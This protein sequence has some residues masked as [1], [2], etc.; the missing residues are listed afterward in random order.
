MHRT[1]IMMVLVSVLCSTD[2]IGQS[3]P[4]STMQDSFNAPLYGQRGGSKPDRLTFAVTAEIA[5]P[6]PLP[7]G[8]PDLDGEFLEI[9]VA[10]GIARTSWS[11]GSTLSVRPAD[12][13]VSGVEPLIFVRWSYDPARLHRSQALPSGL[14]YTQKRQRSSSSRWHKTWKLRVS[15]NN[16]A[17][18][19]LTDRRVFFGSQNNRVYGLRKRNGH[20]V[21]STDLDQRISRRLVHYQGQLEAPP[22]STNDAQDLE[23]ILVLPDPGSRLIALDAATGMLV[24]EYNL[25]RD[26][27]KFVGVPVVTPDAQVV[28]AKES[29]NAAE[30]A[31][32][33]LKLTVRNTEPPSDPSD[34]E[35]ESE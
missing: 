13:P 24:A 21:W 34:V 3:S 28:V 7:S 4:F 15:G 10:G 22:E 27:G 5:L 1:I 32:I 31:L 9:D 26:G 23:L 8:G 30:A 14:I 2:L 6:G 33:V 25:P 18:P 11:A 16:I 19:L 20:Q 17:P 12:S 35:D 29:Y